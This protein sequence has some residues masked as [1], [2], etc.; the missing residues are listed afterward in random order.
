MAMPHGEITLQGPS[1]C[2]EGLRAVDQVPL[3]PFLPDRA[4]RWIDELPEPDV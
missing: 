3:D 2:V 4:R 1:H